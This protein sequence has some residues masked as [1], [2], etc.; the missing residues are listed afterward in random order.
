MGSMPKLSGPLSWPRLHGGVTASWSRKTRRCTAGRT[1]WAIPWWLW[2]YVYIYIMTAMGAN[3]TE[4]WSTSLRS[5]PLRW[6]VDFLLNP[7]GIHQLPSH[8]KFY[9]V[10]NPP[11]P[12][13]ER[14]ESV[15]RY[16]K[17]QQT[18]GS[19]RGIV[20]GVIVKRL[21]EQWRNKDFGLM[22]PWG[23]VANS[24]R[25]VLRDEILSWSTDISMTK[26]WNDQ[27]KWKHIYK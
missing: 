15:R 27:K 19:C 9:A 22:G 20:A 5:W 2:I 4:T 8:K 16:E 14:L 24:P 26:L 12:Q 23:Q 10:L 11:Y 13:A 1:S 3:E 17:T 18:H 21:A 25:R 6:N 7:Q